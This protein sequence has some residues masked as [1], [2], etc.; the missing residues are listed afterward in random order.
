MS[1]PI[2]FRCPKCGSRDVVTDACAAWDRA[3]QTWELRSTHDAMTCQE[4]SCG[5]EASHGGEWAVPL[6]AS[7]VTDLARE[8]ANACAMPTD[9][10]EEA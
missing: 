1:G 8:T 5:Y 3:T 6:V 10:E 2:D 9:I 7:E 4:A